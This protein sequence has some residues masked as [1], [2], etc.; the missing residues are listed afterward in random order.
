MNLR[1]ALWECGG[2]TPLS[3]VNSGLEPPHSQSASRRMTYT[4]SRGELREMGY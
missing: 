1:E 2:L 3:F 4:G